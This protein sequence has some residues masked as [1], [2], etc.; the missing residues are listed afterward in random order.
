MKFNQIAPAD[1]QGEFFEFRED[2]TRYCTEI[3]KGV[4]RVWS[5]YVVKSG[6]AT[7]CCSLTPSSFAAAVGVHCELAPGAISDD[8]DLEKIA[9][10]EM[11]AGAHGDDASRGSQVNRCQP[12][13]YFPFLIHSAE[14]AD[15]MSPLY[16]AETWAD[17]IEAAHANPHFC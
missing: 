6:E 5:R 17:A 1:T 14:K 15:R 8:A 12:A 16:E 3:P 2:V 7:F 10:W 9:D 11:E 4:A 13:A